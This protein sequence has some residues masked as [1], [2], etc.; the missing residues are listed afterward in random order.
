M[1]CVLASQ[2]VFVLSH[3]VPIVYACAPACMPIVHVRACVRACAHVRA[4][5]CTHCHTMNEISCRRS[6]R[7][8]ALQFTLT[9]DYYGCSDLVWQV[10][11]RTRLSSASVYIMFEPCRH[12]RYQRISDVPRYAHPP[13]CCNA[14][15]CQ[16][17]SDVPRYAHLQL[18]DL[19]CQGMHIMCQGMHTGC[20]QI[21]LLTCLHARACARTCKPDITETN[22][23]ANGNPFGSR[24]QTELSE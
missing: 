1:S 18:H 11:L 13:A 20:M 23:S 3:L 4:R 22:E 12:L 21:V 8:D 2:F 15:R 24:L 6:A 14:M 5:V 19:M 7:N 17:I 16:R 9:H 10:Q